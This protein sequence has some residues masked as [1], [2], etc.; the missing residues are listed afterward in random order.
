MSGALPLLRRRRR[1]RA[2]WAAIAL[3]YAGSGA[4]TTA[5]TLYVQETRG[6]GTAIAAFPIAAGGLPVTA[7]VAP[8]L[9]RAPAP[10]ARST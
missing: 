6:T 7:T 4:A 9:L 10:E 8:T 1:F 3:S 5:L 2:L